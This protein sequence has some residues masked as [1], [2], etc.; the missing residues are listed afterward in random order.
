MQQ[1]EQE[2]SAPVSDHGLAALASATNG[3][4]NRNENGNG[5]LS[6]S[7]G[8]GGDST[9][10]AGTGSTSAAGGINEAGIPGIATNGVL[11]STSAPLKPPIP[12]PETSAVRDEE[13]A[14]ATANYLPSD[15]RKMAAA[16][17]AS[18]A[19]AEADR[20]EKLVTAAASAGEETSAAA[21]APQEASSLEIPAD[22][23]HDAVTTSTAPA[24][25][26][27][28]HESDVRGLN[29]SG[30][31]STDQTKEPEET[32][33]TGLPQSSVSDVPTHPTS[34]PGE[35]A[36]EAT[37]SLCMEGHAKQGLLRLQMFQR[38]L[39][40]LSVRQARRTQTTKARRRAWA[41]LR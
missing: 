31:A 5:G 1:Q 29:G 36:T 37:T 28:G 32:H 26:A 20:P 39:A 27:P 38:L 30:L 12:A 19:V 7:I 4:G 41:Y 33:S 3:N 6:S 25:V 11:S 8:G 17:S 16:A 40:R 23:P 24:E 15:D 10:V 9:I 2:D 21:D 35:Y 14:P 18:E 13:P 22:A 34:A